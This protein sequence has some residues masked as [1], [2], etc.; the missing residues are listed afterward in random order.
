M[1]QLVRILLVTAA[2][3]TGACSTNPVTGDRELS[4]MSPAQEVALGEQNYEPYQQQQGGRYYVDPDLTNYVERVGQKLAAQS[5]RDLPYE[6]VVINNGVPNAW[7]LPGGKIAIN[8]GLLALLENEAQLAAVLGHEIVHAAA[9]HTAQQSTQ[10]TLLGLGSAVAGIAAR[11]SDYEQLIGLGTQLGGGAWQAK[12]SRD[13]EL[14]ADRYGVEYMTQAGYNPQGAVELQEKFLELSEG[15]TSNWLDNLFASHPPSQQ[16]V[17]AN[18]K[19]AQEYGTT[20]EIGRE[21]FLA[22]TEQLRQD[23]QAYDAHMKAQQALAKKDYDQAVDLAN[24]AIKGQPEEAIFYHTKGQALAAQGQE[25]EALQV[26]KK[27][28]QQYP[29]Y[30]MGHLG[31]GLMQLELE[32]YAEAQQSLE[33]SVELLPTQVAVFQLG[34]LELRQGDRRKALQYYQYAAQGGGEIAQ[35]AQQRLSELAPQTQQVR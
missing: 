18:R 8:R 34:E 20:G 15:Q 31:Q 35:A 1:R 29:E 3:T 13:H 9:R 12:Y 17:E 23:S 30:F 4:L 10:G 14:E 6:F 11:G 27:G 22:A 24:R 32:Q 19:L 21:D 5:D 28:T 16:R 25:R 33:R 7:A 2:L 26:F